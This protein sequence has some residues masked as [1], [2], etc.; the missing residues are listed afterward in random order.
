LSAQGTANPLAGCTI[1]V[2]A[3]RRSEELIALLERRGATVVHAAAIRIIP[4]VDDVELHRVTMMLIDRPPDVVV[5]TTGIGFRGWIEAAHGWDVSDDLL[6]ALGSTRILARGPKA[7]GA[8]RQAGLREDWS[9][10]SEGSAELIE[11][12]LSDGASG[13]RVAVQLHGAAAEGAPHTDICDALALAGAHVDQVPVYRWQSP[14]DPRPMDQL[15]AMIVAGRLDAVS[16]TSA[17]AVVSLLQRAKALGCLTEL[18]A[19]MRTRVTAVCVGPVTAAP[20]RSLDIP[21]V[22]PD[23]YRLGALARLMTDEIPNRA[24]QFA[25]GGHAIT[26][27][28]GTVSVDGQVRV[29]PPAGMALLRRLIDTSGR[30]VSR[31]ELLTQLPGGGGDRNAVDAAMARLRSALGAPAVIQTVVKRGYRLATDPAQGRGV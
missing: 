8:V 1:G 13:L 29:I 14:E 26:V 25:A 31:D 6:A 4:L 9:P 16:F 30:V 27:R 24:P 15:I 20:L 21:A 2:T 22:Y 12:L 17:P 10:E 23:R 5:V 18:V 28:S 19:A 3:A 7:R 11:R